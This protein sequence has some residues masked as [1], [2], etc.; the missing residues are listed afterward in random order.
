[1]APRVSGHTTAA[2]LSYP[3]SLIM[4]FS[5]VSSRFP[6]RVAPLKVWICSCPNK[7]ACV[8]CDKKNW[9]MAAEGK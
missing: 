9:R 8:G 3:L 7:S 5:Q 1:M 2:N 4:V 6:F